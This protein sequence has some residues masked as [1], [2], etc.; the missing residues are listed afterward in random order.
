MTEKYRY[1][2]NRL[3]LALLMAVCSLFL[4]FD[5]VIAKGVTTPADANEISIVEAKILIYV[6]PVGERV[7]A[8]R[9]DI[10][11]ELQTSTKLN[12]SDYYFFWV[13]DSERHSNGSVTVGYYAV[14][15]HTAEV[16]DMDEDSRLSGKLLLD[17]QELIRESHH[18]DEGTI[19]KYSTSPLLR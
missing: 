4:T 15:K 9:S 13:Y 12:Q 10:A 18:I 6:S 14:N 16:W 19:K 7:R 8:N 3:E 17:I 11:M 1:R 5:S 2:V